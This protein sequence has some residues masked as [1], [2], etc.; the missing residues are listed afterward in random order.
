[1]VKKS[2]MNELQRSN[3]AGFLKTPEQAR[4]LESAAFED[5]YQAC[6]NDASAGLLKGSGIYTTEQ[7]KTYL[8]IYATA[9]RQSID[10][11]K[12]HEIN[13]WRTE[14][15]LGENINRMANEK[16]G[17]LIPGDKKA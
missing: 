3:A 6:I 8:E 10:E 4:Q 1:M 2:K 9:V 16:F 13:G 11:L 17:K 5:G 14:G 7:V 15:T 12:T